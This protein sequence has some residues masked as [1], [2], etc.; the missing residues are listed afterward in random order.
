MTW[1][2]WGR[3]E[4]SPA[5][6]PCCA[7]PPHSCRGTP[8]TTHFTLLTSHYT[9]HTSHLYYFTSFYNATPYLLF[10]QCTTL[11]YRIVSG[12]CSTSSPLH[13][14]GLTIIILPN[15]TIVAITSLL[16]LLYKGVTTISSSQVAEVLEL[17]IVLEMRE[18]Q[19]EEV[20]DNLT[21]RDLM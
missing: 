3:R 2:L 16:N 5:A 17:A 11:F 14:L 13:P 18:V 15:F 19:E 20:S 9:L 4:R 12:S 21:S 6:S 10:S 1:S 7:P 8:R